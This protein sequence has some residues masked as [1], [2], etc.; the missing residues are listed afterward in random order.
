[1]F[2]LALL[3]CKFKRS[4]STLNFQLKPVDMRL[5]NEESSDNPGPSRSA[6]M[7]QKNTATVNPF[8]A[9]PVTYYGDGP[10]THQAQTTRKVVVIALKLMLR[11]YY[12]STSTNLGR[13]HLGE[14]KE[15]IRVLIVTMTMRKY[16]AFWKTFFHSESLLYRSLPQSVLLPSSLFL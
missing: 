3:D 12:F 8:I 7:R 13:R 2:Y 6:E 11:V 10:F 4:T 16:V 15:G 14:Q 9:R 1:M 5:S